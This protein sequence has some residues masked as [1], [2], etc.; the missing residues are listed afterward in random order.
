D[1]EVVLI[2]A[3]LI[4]D[5]P[6]IGY[7]QLNHLQ[8]A[9]QLA[10]AL[11]ILMNDA[12]TVER[13]RAG[14][15]HRYDA[16]DHQGIEHGQNALEQIG[17]H[18][19]AVVN[20]QYA[21]DA[22]AGGAQLGHRARLAFADLRNAIAAGQVEID[23]ALAAENANRQRSGI[24]AVQTDPVKGDLLHLFVGRVAIRRAHD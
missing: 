22:D 12:V 7:R 5:G 8:I 10:S 20:E 13:F 18:R 9:P 2:L 24:A 21:I 11:L 15:H 3:G 23:V 17:I 4:H 16:Q 6:A 14:R 19:T 1:D